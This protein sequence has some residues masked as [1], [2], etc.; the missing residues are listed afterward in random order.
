MAHAAPRRRPSPWVVLGVLCVGQFMT[1]LDTTIVNIAL[2]DLITQLDASLDEALWVYSAYLLSFSTLLITAGRLGDLYGPRRVY[3]IGLTVF[4]VA[5][6][7]CGLSQ[8]PVQ[9]IMAR[10]IQGIGAALLSPQILPIITMVFPPSKWGAAFG[11]TGALS[12]LAVLA[13]PTLGGLVVTAL[14]WRWVFFLNLPIGAVAL[15]LVVRVVHDYRPGIRHRLRLGSVA[16][17]TGG[18]AGLTF[19]LLEGERY[20]WPVWIRTV[21]VAGVVAIIAF[22]ATQWRGRD[23]E[24]LLPPDLFTSRNFTVM[25]GVAAAMGFAMFGAF[26]PLTIY[27]QSVL[28]MSPIEAG[29]T[30]AVMPLVAALVANSAG[31]LSDRFGGKYLLMTGL[32]TFATGLSAVALSAGVDSGALALAPGLGVAGLG[33]GL[34]F[35][36]LYSVAMASVSPRLSGVAS[37]VISTSQELG[38]LLAGAALGAVMQ[39]VL[40]TALTSQATTAAEQLPEAARPDFIESFRTFA[41]GAIK[42]SNAGPPANA[43]PGSQ[44]ATQVFDAAFVQAMRP[45]MLLAAAALFAATLGCIKIKDRRKELT[46]TM[47][48]AT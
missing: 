48:R 3:L 34:I 6:A 45:T 23:H 44:L 33:M 11:L 1:L 35:A 7:I 13:G 19:A 12:G 40:A 18:L 20:G 43:G 4:V 26:L 32:A 24:P 47:D 29:L 17:L 30:I 38:G 22:A 15:P 14:D 2:P 39:S 10:V 46:R 25:T 5:S 16:L 21:M 28:G 41:A 27:L 8:T 36:P 37:G 42:Y 31:R 9:L